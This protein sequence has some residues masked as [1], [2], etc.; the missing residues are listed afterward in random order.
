M[1]KCLSAFHCGD[2]T[3]HYDEKAQFQEKKKEIS[4]LKTKLA[5]LEQEYAGRKVAFTRVHESVNKD[6]E[7]ILIDEFPDEYITNGVSEISL[8]LNGK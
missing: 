8:I 5:K 7:D 2:L 3:K 1:K 4:K 6:V